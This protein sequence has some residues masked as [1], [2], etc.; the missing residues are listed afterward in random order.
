MSFRAFVLVGVVTLVTAFYPSTQPSALTVTK[1]LTPRQR[2]KPRPFPLISM[3]QAA[4]S[5]VSSPS[6]PFSGA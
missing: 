3:R 2:V 1:G 4:L 6:H 5:G